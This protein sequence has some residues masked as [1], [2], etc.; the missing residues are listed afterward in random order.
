MIYKYGEITP[1]TEKAV[2]I[3][4]SADIIGDVELGEDSNIWFNTTLRGDIAPIRVGKGTNIQDGAILHVNHD[5]PCIVGDNVTVGH[6][7]I[8]HAATVK[9]GCLIGM[10]AILLDECEIGEDSVVGAG[11]LVTGGKVFPPRSLIIGSPA[12]KIKEISDEDIAKI[13]ANASE[14]IALGKKT[15]QSNKKQ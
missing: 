8:I 13:R 12:R 15:A 9:E 1:D 11:S 4:D 7:A 5:M 3:A 2:F 6:G 14:Y 10:G